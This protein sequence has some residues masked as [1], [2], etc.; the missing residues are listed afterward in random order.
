MSRAFASR[1]RSEGPLVFAHR[2]GAGV[3]PENTMAAIDN[4]LALGADGVE[5]DV[6]LSR[7]GIPVVIHDPTLDRTTDRT[8]RVGART[9]AELA[10]V[11]AGFR[12]EKDGA[13]PF[14]GQGVGIPRLDAVLAKH[15]D[16]RVIIEM[17]GGEPELAR[18]VGVVV[19]RAGA[20][21]RVCVSSFWQQSIDTL[22]A[23]CPELMTGASQEEARWALHRAWV[24]WPWTS[25]R[26]YAAFQV[27]EHAG[28][29]RVVSPNFVR[30]VHREGHVVQVWVV[31][32]PEDVWRLLDW[33]VDG[34]I[35][36]VPESAIAARNQ[37]AGHHR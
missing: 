37:W 8:G 19:R 29:M 30:H 5:I 9:A 25:E 20:A 14:R 4:G 15:Q 1:F 31:N 11:D 32:L 18:A 22:R 21:D 13:H 6:Q 16:T 33:G 7:D 3:A 36:D 17:K 34:I 27:P 10:H 35:S 28:R 24:R 26:R 2:G 23:D 12:F